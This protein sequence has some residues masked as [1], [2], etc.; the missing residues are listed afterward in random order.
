M[1]K[2]YRNY[3]FES[4]IDWLKKIQPSFFVFENVTGM[5]SAKPDGAPVVDL[6]T[7]EFKK[8]G[9]AIPI[10][11]RDLAINLAELGG[12]QN[13][14]SNNIRFKQKKKDSEI[15]INRFYD[16]LSKEKDLKR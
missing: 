12:F 2:D 13:R 11:N 5:L 4:Y 10:I 9:Y 6:I 7:K 16:Y 1:T 3:L 15:R 14:K 8:A